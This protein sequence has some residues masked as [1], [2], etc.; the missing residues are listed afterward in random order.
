MKEILISSGVL[1]LLILLIRA[2]FRE[3]IPRRLMY[4]L[5]LLVAVR[6]LVPVQ[7][8]SFD[9]SVL[10]V[11]QKAERLAP[12][13]AI[14][15]Q[16]KAPT[17]APSLSVKARPT[18]ENAPGQT[19][20]QPVASKPVSTVPASTA[21]ASAPTAPAVVEAAVQEKEPVNISAILKGVWIFGMIAIAL[22][23]LGVNTY[24]F[25]RLQQ[26]SRPF[27]CPDSFIPL[28]VSPNAES[29]CLVGIFRPVIYLPPQFAEDAE[30]RSHILA[31]ELAHAKQ[32]D[33]LWALV[34][35]L[36]LCIYWFDPLVWVA[37][38]IS[39]QDCELACDEGALQLL[40]E[41]QRLAYGKTLVDTVAKKSNSQS[42]FLSNTAMFGS[43]KSMKERVNAVV[44]K[45]HFAPSAIVAVAV[46]AAVAVGITYT[47]AKKQEQ[48]A[49]TVAESLPTT[50]PT[51]AA[52]QPPEIQE[53][54]PVE[55]P[56]VHFIG[57][58]DTETKSHVYDEEG[59]DISE[60][61]V[62]LWKKYQAAINI[63]DNYYGTIFQEVGDSIYEPDKNHV[64][65]YR[66][67]ENYSEIV[68]S[69]FTENALTDYEETMFD[70]KMYR[71]PV[72]GI[73]YQNS[74]N[75]TGYESRHVDTVLLSSEG[76][77]LQLLTGYYYSALGKPM[78]SYELM[79]WSAAKIDGTWKVSKLSEPASAVDYAKA[80]LEVKDSSGED[81][82][83]E[84]AALWL[85]CNLAYSQYPSELF[86]TAKG[87]SQKV[88]NMYLDVLTNYDAMMDDIFTA[89]G[90][91]QYEN[92]VFLYGDKPVRPFLRYEGKN[93]RLRDYTVLPADWDIEITKADED[94]G[95]TKNRFQLSGNSLFHIE[96]LE[97]LGGLPYS[98]D[99]LPL[100][101]S[102]RQ[103]NLDGSRNKIRIALMILKKENGRWLV[104]DYIHPGSV[105]QEPAITWDGAT[106]D[107]SGFDLPHLAE[108]IHVKNGSA[109]YL[110]EDYYIFGVKNGTGERMTLLDTQ[111]GDFMF[112]RYGYRED[113]DAL[114]RLYLP[115]LEV[116]QMGEPFPAGDYVEPISENEFL[117]Y[118][119]SPMEDFLDENWNTVLNIYGSQRSPKE[120][121]KEESPSSYT[122][123][124]ANSYREAKLIDQI[125]WTLFNGVTKEYFF[126]KGIPSYYQHYENM[127]TGKSCMIGSW[128]HEKYFTYEM[129]PDGTM[130]PEEM[131]EE[132]GKQ[133]WLDEY[134][135]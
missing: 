32:W 63:Y 74:G 53:T 116:E 9:F 3:K 29:P 127:L 41:N 34:R 123:P 14:V 84:A 75:S 45:K 118:D 91:Q 57:G 132:N 87:N 105:D 113:T 131:Q 85:N 65:K 119:H 58:S 114:Y 11:S 23:F 117:R 50:P 81:I 115:T 24:F 66:A 71:D 59:K 22:W 67:V 43:G 110:G 42:L 13:Q 73:V 35:C 12:V 111:I 5:W 77:T 33:N 31:H 90:K 76:N 106:F 103:Y 2:L 72:T 125:K 121:A 37:A 70:F 95:V 68:S 56:E 120:L 60:E 134:Y 38:A 62:E 109:L 82:T 108:N 107:L 4:S 79:K 130:R 86:E 55:Y 98:E 40:Q 96:V 16:F 46:I 52:A 61:I 36:C 135:Q 89:R 19:S 48:K 126:D 28:R 83:E 97:D 129:Y 30:S 15:S 17:E 102:Y 133:W 94:M 99:I 26:G 44:K 54:E 104:E 20:T 64:G 69:I 1:I 49:P 122:T 100:L 80:F 47:G 39:K 88:G 93:L 6:L 8:G 124:N 18:T 10:N 25:F 27:S 21:P 7:I 92:A 112:F 78:Y 128:F 51:T 101:V